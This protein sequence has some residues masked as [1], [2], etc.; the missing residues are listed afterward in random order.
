MPRQFRFNSKS[1]FLTYPQCPLT[2]QQ[3]LDYLRVTY[4]IREYLICQE[5]H[6]IRDDDANAGTHLHA[7]VVFDRKLDIARVDLFDIVH[8]GITYHPNIQRPRSKKA[9][10]EYIQKDGN[11]ITNIEEKETWADAV[12]A[13]N[14]EDFFAIIERADPRSY[15]LYHDKLA[16]Y[17]DAKWAPVLEPEQIPDTA[18]FT[19]IPDELTDWVN[20]E[21]SKLN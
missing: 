17:A 13:T 14:R 11:Y 4:T 9:V 19:N 3:L 16:A 20:T 18:S 7:Y 6:Q 1:A 2:S 21:V 12:K 5:D 8:D 15:V 10:T